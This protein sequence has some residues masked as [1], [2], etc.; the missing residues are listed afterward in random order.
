MEEVAFFLLVE[1]AAVVA[2]L[3]LN[4]AA[5][6]Q[7]AHPYATLVLQQQAALLATAGG[8]NLSLLHELWQVVKVAV[9]VRPQIYLALRSVPN[10]IF[11]YV[12]R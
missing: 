7:R 1:G 6:L 5:P 11:S 12:C 9:V 3:Q 2:L 8:S 10:Q 4:Q